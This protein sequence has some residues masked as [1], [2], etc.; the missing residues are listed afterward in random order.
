MDNGCIE[1]INN[2]IKKDLSVLFSGREGKNI[3][4]VIAE[5]IYYFN[6][7]RLAYSLGYMSLV[8][9]KERLPEDKKTL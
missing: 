5:Y 4:E 9:Y 8:E 6:T 2:W 1:A 7:E 3:R